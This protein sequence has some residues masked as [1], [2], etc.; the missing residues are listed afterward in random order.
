M[1]APRRERGGNGGAPVLVALARTDGQWLHLKIDVLDPEPDGFYDTQPAPVEELGDY[2][3]GSV[4]E[5]EDGGDFFARHDHGDV[6][7]LV[8]ANSIDVVLK[9]MV[10]DALVKEHQGMH[11][12]VLG[13]GSDVSEHGQVSQE[14]FN[15]GAL[16]VNGV[17]MQTEHLSDCIEEFGLLIARR[18]T[19]GRSP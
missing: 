3:G 7:L 5:R 10:E 15:R 2:L 4:H 6:E 18:V 19:Y 13:R 17:V 12:L 11:R 9:R 8:N 1:L 16:G 14:R